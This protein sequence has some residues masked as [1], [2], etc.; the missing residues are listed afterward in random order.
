MWAFGL[1]TL[2]PHGIWTSS[3]NHHHN[4]NSKLRGS[5]IGSFPIMTK[6]RFLNA[7]RLDRFKYLLARHPLTI[8]FGY[9]FIFILGMCVIPF[10]NHP[11]RH[12]DSLLALTVHVAA[13]AALFGWL[14]WQGLVLTLLLPFFLACSLGSYLFYAQHNFPGVLF[15]DKAGWTYEAAALE[16]SSFMTMTPLMRWFT[17]NIGYHHVHHLNARV[18]FYRLPEAMRF[19]QELQAPKTTSL[20]PR[21]IIRCLRLKVWDV[22]AQRMV[23][24]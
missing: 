4:H 2:S 12:W 3:H 5:H 11:R 22:E 17:A 20:H 13:G 8:L 18:P 21:D 6:A 16:S 14:G 1:W 23:G 9:L 24:L 10:L 7:S 15:R 19:I